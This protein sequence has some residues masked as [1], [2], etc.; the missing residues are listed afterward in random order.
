MF[1]VF[2]GSMIHFMKLNFFAVFHLLSVIS[3]FGQS[4]LKG[5]YFRGR[6]FERLVFTRIDP[7]INFNWD[8]NTPG[9]GIP[10]ENYSVRWSGRI[11]V[12]ETGEYVFSALVDDGIRLWVGGVKVFEAWGP[13]DLENVS[14]KVKMKEGQLYE[15]KLEYFNGIL[16]GQVNLFWELPDEDKSIIDRVFRKP[17]SIDS[18]YFSPP[19]APIPDPALEANPIAAIQVEKSDSPP[20]PLLQKMEPKTEPKVENERI[21]PPSEP[22]KKPVAKPTNT[23][24]KMQDTI[25]KYTPKNVLFAPGEPF[26]LDESHP[27]LDRLAKL[28]NRFQNL[29][30]QIDG[31]TDIT[32]DPAINLQLSKD[33]ANEV[34]FYLKEKGINEK[35]IKTQGYGATRPLFGKDSTRL[36]P[37]NRRVEFRIN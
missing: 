37:Q 32:G 11:Q 18:K 15:V 6:N 36:Y 13:H 5:E 24:T 20:T 4:G 26:V 23:R 12:P 31:H 21:V 1:F 8:K 28:L 34:A 2:C 25:D 10:F 33:R 17:Q 29:A 16:E 14:G 35:R 22:T 19:P 27:E 30:V 9:F 7:Q 3:T